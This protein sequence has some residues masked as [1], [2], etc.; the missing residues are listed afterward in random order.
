MSPY[1]ETVIPI[2]DEKTEAQEKLCLAENHLSR[3]QWGYS[4][5]PGLDCSKADVPSILLQCVY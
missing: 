4:S 5:N 2:L 1:Y 3:K